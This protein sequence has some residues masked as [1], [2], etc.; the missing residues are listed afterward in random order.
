MCLVVLGDIVRESK[1]INFA[2]M[3]DEYPDP[4]EEFELMHAEEME[5]LNEMD[6]TD[7]YGLYQL[8][9]LMYLMQM[10]FIRLPF[11]NHVAKFGWLSQNL[12]LTNFKA[13]VVTT[14]LTDF[15]EKPFILR[16]VF[17]LETYS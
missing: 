3:A 1:A 7:D 6:C 14:R 11:Y 15:L 10:A 9:L 5:M 13:G 4:D 2:I 16:T 12:N 8:M 17:F